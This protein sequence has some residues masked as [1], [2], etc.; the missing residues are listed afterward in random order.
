VSL[1]KKRES[2]NSVLEEIESTRVFAIGR[3]GVRA[4]RAV[5]TGVV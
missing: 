3:E 4:G 5:A 2:F 1:A